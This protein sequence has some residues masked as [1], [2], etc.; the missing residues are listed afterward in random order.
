MYRTIDG[1]ESWKLAYENEYIMSVAV[2]PE[3]IISA[4]FTSG[5]LSETSP[6][7]M[8]RSQDGEAWSPT[9]NLP[10]AILAQGFSPS[11]NIGFAIGISATNPSF[12]YPRSQTLSINKSV[13]KGATWTEFEITEPLYGYPLA[14]AFPSDN[15]AYVLGFREVMKFT[16]P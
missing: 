4:N 3:N 1:G 2:T 12:D 8:F 15:V 13:D 9:I 16:R 7:T 10:Y 5:S 11:G 14:V 6:S